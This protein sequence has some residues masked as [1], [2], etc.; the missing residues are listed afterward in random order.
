MSAVERLSILTQR[1][2]TYVKNIV[3]SNRTNDDPIAN[4]LWDTVA[5]LIKLNLSIK[6]RTLH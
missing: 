5:F 4:D 1:R 6:P 2:A 3:K